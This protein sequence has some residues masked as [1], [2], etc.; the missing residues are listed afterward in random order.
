MGGKHTREK[1][2]DVRQKEET[3]SKKSQRAIDHPGLDVENLIFILNGT[4]G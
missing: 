3:D 4:K 1:C 2:T